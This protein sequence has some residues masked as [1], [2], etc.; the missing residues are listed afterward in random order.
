MKAVLRYTD[1]LGD[2]KNVFETLGELN[3]TIIKT[4]PDRISIYPKI[5]IKVANYL[6]L[7]QI[8]TILNRNTIYGV[9][10]IKIK[11]SLFERLFERI[12]EYV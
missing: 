6:E 10:F 9:R 2:E 5:I 4:I 1:C 8:L 11:K 7:N 3:V 12:E